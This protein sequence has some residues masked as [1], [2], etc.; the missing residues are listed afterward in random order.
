MND[1]LINL[2]KVS[3]SY[4]DK[5]GRRGEPVLRDVSFN[6][7]RGEFVCVVGPN[8]GGKSTLLKLLLGLERPS[9]GTVRLFGGDPELSS[10]RIG[11]LP[12]NPQFDSQFP[13]TVQDVV[14]MGRLRTGLLPGLYSSSDREAAR[15]ALD[16]V[17]MGRASAK[18]FGELSG[19]QRQRVLIARMLATEPDILL[20]DEPTSYL[21]IQAEQELYELLNLLNKRLTIVIVSHDLLIVS[22]FVDRVVCV[23]GTVDIHDTEDVSEELVGEL[24]GGDVRMVVHADHDHEHEP[25]GRD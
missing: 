1:V 11:Y 7:H 4:P 22:G 24:Y 2:E 23:K 9:S 19:G 5:S 13:V 3:F 17:G 14:L 18:N 15:S 10:P 16:D 8:G 12:Q 21:D 6:V 20:L 25:E